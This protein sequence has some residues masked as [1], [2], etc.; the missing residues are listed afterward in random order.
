MNSSAMTAT[1]DGL[2][3]MCEGLNKA[4]KATG[5]Y[6]LEVLACFQAIEKREIRKIYKLYKE[7]IHSKQ[8]TKEGEYGREE[9]E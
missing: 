1:M 9:R 6:F 2:R 5:K 8:H 3:L 7:S 4:P